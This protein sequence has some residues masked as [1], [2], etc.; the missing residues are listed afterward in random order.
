MGIPTTSEIPR[1]VL[2]HHHHHHHQPLFRPSKRYMLVT[3]R[4]L[5]LKAKPIYIH[6]R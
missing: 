2:F 3:R 1:C 6:S 4:L 5:Q